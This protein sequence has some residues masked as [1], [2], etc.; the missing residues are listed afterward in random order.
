ML[1]AMGTAKFIAKEHFCFFVWQDLPMSIAS[2]FMLPAEVEKIIPFGD[3]TRSRMEKRGLFPKRIRVTPRRIAWRR[4]EI[5]T[6]VNDPEGW[7]KRHI[8]SAT[9]TPADLAEDL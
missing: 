9:V 8:D 3:L 6:W 1:Q 4:T 2:P 5:E 7:P